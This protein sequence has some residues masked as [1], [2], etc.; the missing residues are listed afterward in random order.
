M[1]GTPWRTSPIG[2]LDVV[3]YD[4]ST[5]LTIWVQDISRSLTISSISLTSLDKSPPLELLRLLD[6][7]HDIV[8]CDDEPASHVWSFL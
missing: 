4:L 7:L 5:R 6:C 8:C 3:E 1:D 2:V